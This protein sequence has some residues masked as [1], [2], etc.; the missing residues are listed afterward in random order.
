LWPADDPITS[1]KNHAKGAGSGGE[2]GEPD[3]IGACAASAR[4]IARREFRLL[5]S[6]TRSDVMK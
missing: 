4:A 6:N 1:S 5:M 3:V 2:M